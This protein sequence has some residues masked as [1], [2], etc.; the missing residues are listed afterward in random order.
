[1]G[2]ARLSGGDFGGEKFTRQYRMHKFSLA[3]AAW[4]L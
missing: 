3:P 2:S 1:M 4:L